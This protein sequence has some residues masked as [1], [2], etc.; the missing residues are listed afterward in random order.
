[1]LFKWKHLVYVPLLSKREDLFAPF[2][3]PR[4]SVEEMLLMISKMLLKIYHGAF[5]LSSVG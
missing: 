4:R 5:K 2:F 3:I 1:M